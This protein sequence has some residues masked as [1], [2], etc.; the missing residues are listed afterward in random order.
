MIARGA[1]GAA[2]LV[3]EMKTFIQSGKR[4]EAAAGSHDDLVLAGAH[5]VWAGARLIPP[6]ARAKRFH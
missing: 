3:D 5:T 1:K 2:L 4:P 6:T